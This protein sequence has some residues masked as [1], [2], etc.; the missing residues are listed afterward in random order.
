VAN[1]LD[2]A[3][4]C[5]DDQGRALHIIHRA[6]SPVTIRIGSNGRLKL[7]NFGAAFSELLGR[8]PTPPK[9]LRGN[10]AYAAPEIIH[11]ISEKGR[12]GLLSSKGIDSRV[13]IFSLGLVLLE[14]IAGNHPL[15]PLDT[16]PPEVSKRALRL[17]SGVRAE[18]SAWASIEVL[19]DRLL[20]FGPEDVE[21]IAFKAPAPLRQIAH[22]ALRS[23]PAERYQSAAEMRDDLRAYLRSLSQPFGA[24][25]A[26]AELTDILKKA[27]ALKRKDAHPVELGVLPWPKASSIR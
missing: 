8:V 13:D 22:R 6:V 3:H 1:A 14:M 4:H 12:A 15:D 7:T 26:A 10:F 25:E 17:V 5:E 23:D 24:T 20:R 2:Y 9:V 16:L 11:S 27:S 21:R 19:A 18:Q